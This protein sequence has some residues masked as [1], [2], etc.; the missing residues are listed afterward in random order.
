MF[1]ISSFFHQICYFD[2]LQRLKRTP[3]RNFPLVAA[4]KRELIR[5]RVIVEKKGTFGKGTVLPRIVCPT[6]LEKVEEHVVRLG[7][8][9]QQQHQNHEEPLPTT[10]Q[11]WICILQCSYY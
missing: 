5:D 10:R 4:W 6:Q 11:V 8:Q 9:T 3:P 7:E 1:T 2:R